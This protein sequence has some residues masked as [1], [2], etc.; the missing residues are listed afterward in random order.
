MVFQK[1]PTLDLMKSIIPLTVTEM[2]H[3]KSMENST[4]R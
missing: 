1:R 4:V 2:M 3:A